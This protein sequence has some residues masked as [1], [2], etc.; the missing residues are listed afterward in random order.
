MPKQ[1][2]GARVP[3]LWV[4]K[5]KALS[6]TTGLSQTELIYQA[7]GQYLSEDV[8]TVGDRLSTI[9]GEVSSIKQ[10][11]GKLTASLMS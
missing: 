7:I 3:E 1:M 4:S 6:E 2:V 11:L 8:S 5:L 10:R 9:E